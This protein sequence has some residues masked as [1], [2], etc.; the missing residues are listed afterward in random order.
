MAVAASPVT[1]RDLRGQGLM[2]TTPPCPESPSRVAQWVSPCPD[3]DAEA[4]GAPRCAL[5][6]ASGPDDRR[7]HIGHSL[8]C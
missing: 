7:A 4:Q 3:G 1:V 8:D 6:A 5:G 2:C